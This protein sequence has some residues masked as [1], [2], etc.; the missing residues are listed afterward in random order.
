MTIYRIAWKRNEI[1]LWQWKSTKLS[2]LHA[3]FGF[4]R[5]YHTV[6]VERMRVFSSCSLEDLN[7]QLRQENER[8]ALLIAERLQQERQTRED[9]YGDTEAIQEM[10]EAWRQKQKEPQEQEVHVT[11]Y[12]L[13]LNEHTPYAH[14][15]SSGIDASGQRR[16]EYESGQGG[17]HDVPYVYA[18]PD[19][20]PQ[21]LAWTRLLARVQR[22]ELEL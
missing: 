16:L 2:T 20:L 17:D 6:P 19:S 21:R 8:E 18:L 5:L 1:A 14:F 4:L 13:S 12:A 15:F 9:G 7:E 3:V 11:R 10:L 22:G